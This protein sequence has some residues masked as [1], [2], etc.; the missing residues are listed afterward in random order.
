MKKVSEFTSL[1]TKLVATFY[2]LK[3][4]SSSPIIVFLTGD[5]KSG[6]LSS[7]WNP[8]IDRLLS[9]ELS[10]FTFDFVSQGNSSGLRSALTLDVGITNFHDA[11]QLLENENKISNR[12]LGF[13]GSSFGANVLLNS[14]D[15]LSKADAVA[16]KSPA[17][18][19]YEAYENEHN[20][21][22]GIVDWEKDKVSR[23]TE[24]SFQAYKSSF[25]SSAYQNIISTN[26]PILIVHGTNDSVVPITQS[27]RIKLLMKDKCEL[28]ELQNVDHDYKQSNAMD[29]L[30]NS[31]DKFFV[32][33][34]LS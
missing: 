21:I 22:S 10:V 6:T 16:L 31:V 32:N 34:L 29:N 3:Q 11:F 4:D 30:I 33:K 14:N 18:L 23:I 12:K 7:T 5:G 9:R 28:V 19:L 25:R 2:S 26:C 1:G 15:I 13:L 27:R 8:L 20:G 17:V 24:L